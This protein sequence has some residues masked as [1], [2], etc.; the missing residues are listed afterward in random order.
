MKT[1]TY[2]S[3]MND[4]DQLYFSNAICIISSILLL[5]VWFYWFAKV[6]FWI[7]QNSICHVCGNCFFFFFQFECLFFFT[8]ILHHICQHF[9]LRLLRFMVCLGSFSLLWGFLK[10]LFYYYCAFHF[11]FWIFDPFKI[12]LKIDLSLTPK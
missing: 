9:H 10:N 5:R 12:Y 6:L 8:W 7:G 2:F 4:T 1:V 11:Y 3:F